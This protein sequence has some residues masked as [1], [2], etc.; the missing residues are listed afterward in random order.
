MKTLDRIPTGKIERASKLVSTGVK[1]G[2]NYIKYI[3]DKI[4]DPENARENLD[5]ENAKDIYD[6]LKTLKG[7]ALKVAQMLSM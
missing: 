3:G 7:S 6:G 2:G 5:Q 4:I 1:L